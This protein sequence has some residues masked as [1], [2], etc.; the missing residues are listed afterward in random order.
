MNAVGTPDDVTRDESNAGF[1]RAVAGA[2]VL[3]TLAAVGVTLVAVLLSA[4]LLEA[5][6]KSAAKEAG[7]AVKTAYAVRFRVVARGLEDMIKCREKLL[8]Y[9]TGTGTRLV[10]TDLKVLGAVL[11]VGELAAVQEA[12]DALD[13]LFQP[14]YSAPPS[15][16]KAA[17]RAWGEGRLKGRAIR[18]N[19]LM[20]RALTLLGTAEPTPDG[21]AGRE[22]HARSSAKAGI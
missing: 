6:K 2:Q 15:H 19:N 17:Y 4:S 20:R 12:S 7:D 1:A 13:R 21:C 3:A 8:P 10:F 22:A 18:A 11:H 14:G 16:T 9:A 5:Q